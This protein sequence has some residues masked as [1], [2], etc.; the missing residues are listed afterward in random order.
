MAA[1]VAG[2]EDEAGWPTVMS[3]AAAG[4][5]RLVLE[6]EVQARGFTRASSSRSGTDLRV[7][8]ELNNK[9]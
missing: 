4:A 5:M 9:S 8:G 2:S 7:D 3:E 6:S 1:E